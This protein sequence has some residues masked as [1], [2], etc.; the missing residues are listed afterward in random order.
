MFHTARVVTD[1]IST[2]VRNEYSITVYDTIYVDSIVYRDTCDSQFMKAIIETETRN[3]SKLA[4]EK[5]IYPSIGAGGKYIGFFQASE[6]WFDGCELAHALQYEYND[7]FDPKKSY[8]VFWAKMGVYAEKLHQEGID[9][10]TP[11]HLVNI[12]EKLARIHAG[13]YSNR[14][15]HITNK[16]ANAFLKNFYKKLN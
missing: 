3:Y 12:Y 13:G 10:I 7:M 15:S 1:S 4:K 6:I 5:P 9:S 14:N 8:H 16:Y 2:K 11:K